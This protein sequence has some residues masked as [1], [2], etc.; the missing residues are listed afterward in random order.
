LRGLLS[1]QTR[2]WEGRHAW[3]RRRLSLDQ[4]PLKSER[5][6]A[7]PNEGL[8][9]TEV[10]RTLQIS[11]ATWN[12]CRNQYAGMRGEHMN[13]HKELVVQDQCLMLV[14]DQA[15]NIM[16]A[17]WFTDTSDEPRASPTGRRGFDRA[18]RGLSEGRAV[19]QVFSTPP[20]GTPSTL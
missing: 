20:S 13:R 5:A 18:L 14:S 19:G 2:T 6:S 11:E 9:L 17:S 15:L 16:L 10:L 1:I 12:R 4:A 8:D 7:F 3:K